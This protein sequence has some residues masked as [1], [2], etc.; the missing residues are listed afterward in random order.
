MKLTSHRALAHWGQPCPIQLV[1]LPP[2]HTCPTLQTFH[3]AA[4]F[5]YFPYFTERCITLVLFS[6]T[7]VSAFTSPCSSSSPTLKLVGIMQTTAPTW[8][9][10]ILY[11]SAQCVLEPNIKAPPTL[12]PAVWWF[13]KADF[14]GWNISHQSLRVYF[15]CVIFSSHRL[16]Y[17]EAILFGTLLLQ[18]GVGKTKLVPYFCNPRSG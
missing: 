18:I 1:L 17:L 6:T 7:D 2:L 3:N 4:Y 15:C 9:F 8:L 5:S 10:W 11:L 14:Y 12:Q 13:N 16:A